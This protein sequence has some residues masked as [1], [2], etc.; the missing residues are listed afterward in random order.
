[1][2]EEIASFI[3]AQVRRSTESGD[4]EGAVERLRQFLELERESK[5]TSL[6]ARQEPRKVRAFPALR[7]VN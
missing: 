3:S 4:M 2:Q 7:A 5:M 1:M 6:E